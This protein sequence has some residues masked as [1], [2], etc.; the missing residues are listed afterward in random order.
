MS[1]NDKRI[2]LLNTILGAAQL[3]GNFALARKVKSDITKSSKPQT[4]IVLPLAA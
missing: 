1:Q 3:S 4:R 2:A